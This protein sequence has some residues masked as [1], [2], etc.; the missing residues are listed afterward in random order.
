MLILFVKSNPNR[1]L[2]YAMIHIH[3]PSTF[4]LVLFLCLVRLT[5]ANKS[6]NWLGPSIFVEGPSP[7]GRYDHG[8][9]S[10]DN[11]LFI[12]GGQDNDG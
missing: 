6:R 7:S 2:I 11:K 4:K 9:A 3:R 5:S 12:F 10:V 8:F 1:K